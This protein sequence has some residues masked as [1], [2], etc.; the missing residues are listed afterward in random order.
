MAIKNHPL[1]PYFALFFG[2]M[3]I[4]SSAILV[5]LAEA[6]G[7]VTAFYRMLIGSVVLVIPFG[8]NI[9]KQGKLNRFGVWMAIMAGL[10]FGLDIAM[11]ATGVMLSGATNPTLMGNT[12]PIWVGIGVMIFFKE[13]LN[14]KFW[15]GL[16]LALSGAVAVLGLDMQQGDA[17][18]RGTLY[19][20]LAGMFYGGFFLFTQRGREK[21]DALSFFWI[22]SATSAVIN[23]I[24]TQIL[25]QPLTGYPTKTY[26]V[27]VAIGVIIQSI[28][29]LVI[30]YVQG[31]LPASIVAPTLL[32]QPVVTALIAAPVLGEQF[33]GLQIAGG[34]AVLAGVYIVHR[35]RQ[36]E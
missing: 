19:G 8:L 11:W 29:W 28:G 24:F 18:G 12:A 6:P 10:F 5:R 22:S 33:S 31:H 27:F 32:G 16:L 13:K 14:W 30:N 2:L 20:L 3:A 9:R 36:K 34:A 26:W 7:P 15:A 25:G 17:I 23:L 21:L 1:L 35:S 4:G